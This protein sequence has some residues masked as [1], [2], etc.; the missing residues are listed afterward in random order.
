[1]INAEEIPSAA[2]STPE[3]VPPDAEKPKVAVPAAEAHAAVACPGTP[4]ASDFQAA[5]VSDETPAPACLGPSPALSSAS[6]LVS[7]DADSAVYLATPSASDAFP[8][9]DGL[10]KNQGGLQA[11]TSTIN[12]SVPVGGGPD[13]SLAGS[14]VERSAPFSSAPAAACTGPPAVVSSLA[15]GSRELENSPVYSPESELS[16]DGGRPVDNLPSTPA[17]TD[18]PAARLETAEQ[19]EAATIA[20][21]ARPQTSERS[22]VATSD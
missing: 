11:E 1:M 17:S 13:V 20:S 4:P 16:Y 6:F 19:S 12:A 7:P 5:Q 3:E 15:Q 9:L 8:S 21:A 18:A 22:E 2:P 10:P 14:T